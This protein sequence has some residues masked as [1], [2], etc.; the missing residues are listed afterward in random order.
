MT[1]NLEEELRF[2]SQS[3]FAYSQK[4]PTLSRQCLQQFHLKALAIGVEVVPTA[5]CPKCF[6]VYI[7]GANCNVSTMNTFGK[8]IQFGKRLLSGKV[9]DRIYYHCRVCNCTVMH[10]LSAKNVEA[11]DKLTIEPPK[12]H[13]QSPSPLQVKVAPKPSK[14]A[15]KKKNLEQLLAKKELDS[16]KTTLSL[17]DFL[18]NL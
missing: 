17:D 10:A 18:N 7:P 16:K 9:G 14:K 5:Y 3:A 8:Q 2:L 15:K 1:D 6:T 12:K 4:S 11:T 13:I